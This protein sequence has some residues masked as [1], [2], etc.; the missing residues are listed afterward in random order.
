MRERMIWIVV[1][2][3]CSAGA[4][5]AGR[6][7]GIATAQAQAQQTSG[8]FFADRGGGNA[9]SD[10]AQHQGNGG[11]R[12]GFGATGQN[13]TGTVDSID[14]STLTI[15][16]RDNT[17]AKVQLNADATIRKQVQGQPSD[18]HVGDFVIVN[19]T[20]NGDVLQAAGVQIGN[21]RPGAANRTGNGG[22]TQ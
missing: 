4:F 8:R 10:A 13:V 3:L 1:L 17:T 9:A 15:K 19:G 5:Y 18:I 12:R 2:L 6:G 22:A 20:K 7:N 14:G 11:A 16:L 21:N